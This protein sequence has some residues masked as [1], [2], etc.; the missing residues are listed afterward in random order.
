MQTGLYTITKLL[1][2]L[3]GK[4]KQLATASLDDVPS[5]SSPWASSKGRCACHIFHRSPVGQHSAGCIPREKYDGCLPPPGLLEDTG[6]VGIHFY[7]SV[8]LVCQTDGGTKGK[9]F[10]LVTI[11]KI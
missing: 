4:K 5:C 3:L 8:G 9:I 11:K 7:N 2:N 6:T 1:K 10:V